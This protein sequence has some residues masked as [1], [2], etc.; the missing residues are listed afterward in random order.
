MLIFD[1]GVGGISILQEVKKVNPHLSIVYLFDNKYFPYG[2]LASDLLIRRTCQ[3]ITKAVKQER[4]DLVV[5]ACNSASTLVMDSIRTCLNIPVVGV[6]PA[7]K[8]AAKLT[9]NQVIGLLA[10]PG[11][12]TRAYTKG[13]IAEFAADKTVLT[14]GTTEL[15]RLA[16][17]KLMGKEIRLAEL[18][19][20]LRPWLVGEVVPDTIVLGCTHFPLLSDELKA[21]LGADVNLVDS[22]EAIAR[23]TISLFQ[24]VDPGRSEQAECKVLCTRLDR[25]TQALTKPLS[26]WGLGQ[27][28]QLE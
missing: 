9:K 11:T 17:D 21:V 18:E 10:T 1:S 27:V 14:I 5:V 28:E 8:P 20:I 23:R 13:L 2:E 7:I 25:K 26:Q 15:V 12:V 6:V 16:E 24:S 3:I 19:A 22:G 4:A